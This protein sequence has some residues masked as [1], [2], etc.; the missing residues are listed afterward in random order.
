M[1]R[2]IFMLN[3]NEYLNEVCGSLVMLFLKIFFYT[4]HHNNINIYKKLKFKN[5]CL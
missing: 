2:S 5:Y 3:K 4:V 1:L